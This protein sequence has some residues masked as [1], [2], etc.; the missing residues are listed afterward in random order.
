[1]IATD[2]VAAADILAGID[3]FSLAGHGPPPRP[4]R[5][6]ARLQG[7]LSVPVARIASGSRTSGG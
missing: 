7:G 1:V 5:R 6:G 4:H 2:A 3:P